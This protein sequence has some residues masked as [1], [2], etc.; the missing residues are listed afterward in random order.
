M[1]L[2]IPKHVNSTTLMFWQNSAAMVEINIT[3][4]ASEEWTVRR[5][6]WII[7][8]WHNLWRCQQLFDRCQISLL[9]MALDGQATVL[10]QVTAGKYRQSCGVFYG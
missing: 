8:R 1:N 6:T 5:T 7:G 2:E 4:A 10:N 3:V 9:D